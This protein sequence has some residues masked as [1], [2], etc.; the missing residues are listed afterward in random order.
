[1]KRAKARDQVRA[2]SSDPV[3]SHR[4]FLVIVLR[5]GQG[6]PRPRGYIEAG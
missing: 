2:L 5:F 4:R 6:K 1:M 3:D